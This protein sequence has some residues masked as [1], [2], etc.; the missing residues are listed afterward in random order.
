MNDKRN[1]ANIID[2]NIYVENVN[3]FRDHSSYQSDKKKKARSQRISDADK[4]D[5]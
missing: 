3:S 4:N 2:D 5:V 1:L